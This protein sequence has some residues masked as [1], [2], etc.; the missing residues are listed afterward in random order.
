MG[1]WFATRYRV[2]RDWF[3]SRFWMLE[4]RVWF[5]PF[6]IEAAGLFS[7]REEA[8]SMIEILRTEYRG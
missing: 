2:N 6:W 4:K 7:T 5:W 8:V 3:D 1:D